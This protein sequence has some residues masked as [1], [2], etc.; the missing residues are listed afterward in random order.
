MGCEFWGT[1]RRILLLA[2]EDAASERLA[3]AIRVQGDSLIR[4]QA[5][6]AAES[7]LEHADALIVRPG[8]EATS[9]TADW[10]TWLLQLCRFR[11]ELAVVV[12]ADSITAEERGLLLEAGVV[13]IY[14]AGRDPRVAVAMLALSGR[15]RR[16]PEQELHGLHLDARS[17]VVSNS[18]AAVRLSEREFALLAHLLRQQG[19]VQSRE[20]LLQAVW[21]DLF[22][23]EERTVDATLSRL[24]RRLQRELGLTDAIRTVPQGGYVID[25][26][27]PVTR[28]SGALL[29]ASGG[30]RLHGPT[31]A[32]DE[33]LLRLCQLSGLQC[34]PSAGG[35]GELPAGVG[36]LLAD[37][38]GDWL[39]PVKELLARSPEAALM[40]IDAGAASA[41]LCTAIDCGVRWVVPLEWAEVDLRGYLGSPERDLGSA[42]AAESLEL[43][44]DAFAARVW[45]VHVPLPRRD[46]QVLEVL[47]RYAGRPVRREQLHQAVWGRGRGNAKSSLD[48]A[49]GSLRRAI[50]SDVGRPPSIETVVGVGYRLR[51]R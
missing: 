15:W 45:G 28:D 43:L 39:T 38:T 41:D 5:A 19:R 26:A 37:S 21:G 32:A 35:G 10:L 29:L 20:A 46:Y 14:P 4:V 11:A 44:P 33:V 36:L 2:P 47:H 25:E 22:Q 3:H 42:S 7:L 18:L 31:A 51:L 48:A 23:V 12:V 6:A 1:G 49:I 30:V 9:I 40:L 17:L 34:R 13:A 50:G 27:A 16:S 8:S 24:R